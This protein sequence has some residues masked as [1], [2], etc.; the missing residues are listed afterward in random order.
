MPMNFTACSSAVERTTYL[1]LMKNLYW[2]STVMR[3]N[4]TP[5]TA[6]A[7]R[8]LPTRSHDRGD[9]KRFSPAKMRIKAQS[10]FQSKGSWL[11][12]LP[13]ELTKLGTGTTGDQP[14]A[15]GKG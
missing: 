3:K 9:T 13:A 10:L 5:S 2:I 6:M 1:G 14:V 12:F 15:G 11:A 8:F 7:K 4:T